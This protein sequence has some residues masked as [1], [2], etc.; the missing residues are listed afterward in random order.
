[1]KKAQQGHSL[2]RKD[3]SEDPFEQFARWYADAGTRGTG[4]RDAMALATA[5][6][7]GRPSVRMVLL[8]GFD[9]EG[10]RFFTSYNSRKGRELAV[11][12][13]AAI[14]FH[15]AFSDRQ[16]RIEGVCRRL[17]ADAS[18]TYF[19]T[20][21]VGSRLGAHAS[22]QSEV[23]SDRSDL[24]QSLAEAAARFENTD[25]PRPH[26][27]GGYVL[28]PSLFE[29]WQAGEDRL[30]DRFRYRFINSRWKIERLAP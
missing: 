28:S 23:I 8:K 27:W 5:D 30:H 19:V 15:W 17:P 25:I 21:P 16:I 18:D 1:M 6:L 26:S 2:R 14:L 20:R 7:S 4:D 9:L 3:L 11:N 22:R 13:H 10:F 29:F 12:P 24:E